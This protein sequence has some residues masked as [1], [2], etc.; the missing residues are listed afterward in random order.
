MSVRFDLDGTV[1]C[2]SVRYNYK[3]ARNLVAYGFGKSG[4]WSSEYANAFTENFATGNKYQYVTYFGSSSGSNMC[5][6]S[7]PIPIANHKYYGAIHFKSSSGFSAA[8]ARFEW[9]HT[10]GDTNNNLTFAQKNFSTN[11]Q[12]VILSAIVQAGSNPNTGAWN[13]RNFMVAPNNTSAYSSRAMIID[14]TDTFGAGNEPSK[15][16]CDNNIL[17]NSTFLIGVVYAVPLNTTYFSESSWHTAAWYNYL[18]LNSNWE[19]RECMFYCGPSD[20]KN[21]GYLTTKLSYSLYKNYKYYG[22]MLTKQDSYNDNTSYDCYFPIAE[23]LLGTVKAVWASDFNGG[24]GMTTWK[25]RTMFNNRTSFSTE[26]Y[27]IR[28]D[29]NN[30]KDTSGV[31]FT[32]VNMTNVN[33]VVNSYNY[34][35]GQSISIND[36]NREWCDR[37]VQGYNWSMLRIKDHKNTS[38]EF[39]R[40][41]KEMKRTSATYYTKAQ[42]DSWATLSTDTWGAVI[43]GSELKLGERA[44][45]NVIRSDDNVPCRFVVLVKGISG[46]TITTQNLGYGPEGSTWWNATLER[47]DIVCNDI[48]IRPEINYIKFDNTGTLTCKKL[49]KDT[50]Y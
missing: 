2:Y 13:I 49:I 40:G 1:H 19:P 32:D 37:W 20:D 23:P 46:Q 22:S 43:N 44:F 48:E 35:F 15:E 39:A 5:S 11:G 16:W 29:Y 36:V 6:Q 33:N 24:G 14:L 18:S 41:V 3:Q 38:I 31:R 21:E 27:P 10:D 25:R 30:L 26:Y 4:P 47:D 17:E 8:D 50:A 42:M 28:Y 45:M 12:W 9:Y 7:M 34:Q